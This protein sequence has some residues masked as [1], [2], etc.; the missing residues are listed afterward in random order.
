MAVR[1]FDYILLGLTPAA[2]LVAIALSAQADARGWGQR[3]HLFIVGSSTSFPIIGAMVERFS[4]SSAFNSPVVESTGTGGGFKSF[5]GGIGAHTPDIAMASREIKPS[6]RHL[7]E[8]NLVTDIIRLKIGYDGIAVVHATGQP[9]FHLT[10]SALYQ[11]LSKYVPSPTDPARLVPNPYT[12]WNQIDSELPELPILVYGPPPTSGTRDI[13]VEKVIEQGCLTFP[14][15]AAKQYAAPAEFRQEC[16]ALR[17]DGAYVNAGENDMRLVR[18]LVSEPKAVGIIGYNFLERNIDKLQAT[19]IEGIV[20][21]F[22]EIESGRYPI[23]RPLYLYIKK[24]HLDLTP[25]LHEFL[26]ELTRDQA[27]GPDGYLSD[28]GL[29]PLSDGERAAWLSELISSL[30]H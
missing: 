4:R 10:R 9:R 11:A 1:F 25:G 14:I 20:P 13:L 15:V 23:S 16:H 5:C 6:E 2:V 7:C 3:E 27:W 29:I 21:A 18:K 12:H 30:E 22:E 24:A 28:K 19:D 17:E 8:Q 26:I